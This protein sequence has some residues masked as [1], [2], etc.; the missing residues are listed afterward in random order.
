VILL[1]QTPHPHPNPPL[2]PLR[3]PFHGGEGTV[4]R[5]FFNSSPFKGEAG[6]GMGYLPRIFYLTLM[7]D[8]HTFLQRESYDELPLISVIILNWNGEQILESCL[9]SLRAQTYRPLELIVVDNASTDGSTSLVK[10]KFPEVRLIVNERN[11]G[12]GGGN[13]IGIQVSG[14]RYVMILNNDARL[15]RDCVLELKRAIEKDEGYGACASRIFL[16]G[17]G[18]ILDAAGIAIFPDG[19]SI[20]R[21]RLESGNLYDREEEVFFSSG[22]AC[23]YR[24]EMLND[25]GMF[26][27]D[28]FAYADD[29]DMGWRAQLAGW[30]CIYNPKAIVYHRHSASSSAYS[31]LKAFLVERNRL[32]VAIK[33]FP[34]SLIILGQFFTL[35]RYACQAY[36][37]FFGKGAAGRFTAQFS[38]SQLL[39]IL[40]KVYGAVIKQLPLILGKRK[41]GRNKRRISNREIYGLLRK[42]GISARDL[43]FKE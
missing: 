28:F 36:G 7:T 39:G 6:R 37:A 10:A 2:D 4:G 40:F 35:W 23:L 21:G 32:W 41:M 12:F 42:Y 3:G 38:K 25:I 8:T 30:R 29:T 27:E 24:R 19:L 33:H 1:P 16:E 15:D 9:L 14:G 5:N 34:V 43:A 13:N 26:D 22:C 31:P 11:L 18:D 17:E 20:G